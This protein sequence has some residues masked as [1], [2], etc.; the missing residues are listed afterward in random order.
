MIALMIAAAPVLQL[1]IAC[2]PGRDCFIQSLPDDDPG[3]GAKDYACGGR[4]Y[5]KH[6]GT[7]I[8]IPS[9]A[10]Q[11]E[12]VNV[13][14]AAAGTVL[15]VRDGVADVSIRQA[16]FTP[17]Q[18]C[19]NGLVI[20]HGGGWETQ[21]CHMARGSLAVKPGQSV[22]AGT[23]LGRVGLSGNTEFP[24]VHLTVRENGKAVDPFAYGAAPG[25]CRGGRSLWAATP[26]YKRGEV[27]V[28]GFAAGPVSMAQAQEMGAAQQ[29][30]PGRATPLVAFVQAIGLEAGD[31]Q[32]LVLKGPDGQVLVD[33]RAEPLDRAK[34][35]TIII[36]GR[37][38]RPAGWP[39]GDYRARYS[40][41]R[42]GK[43]A[44]VREFGIRL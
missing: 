17:G 35:Q 15:R 2:V 1:P 12:G 22:A 39:A 4:T 25:Q 31:V 14:A 8:R 40:V 41:A 21:Y 29:P 13:L 11:R 20:D 28:A 18:D 6:D 30:R 10:R 9:M 43:E 34:A 36:A 19:G 33:N 3:P 32:R 23:V 27:I 26:A 16:A 38:A 37:G 5:D 42:D 44:I 7:D 24:H